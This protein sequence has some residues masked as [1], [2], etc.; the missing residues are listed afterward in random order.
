MHLCD[1]LPG[2][3][4]GPI[5]NMINYK[6]MGIHKGAEEKNNWNLGT[7]L[8]L[9]IKK[10][11]EGFCNKE[12]NKNS[13]K[14]I[15]LNNDINENNS[16]DKKEGNV[17]NNESNNEF[18]ILGNIKAQDNEFNEFSLFNE[19]VEEE[20][21]FSNNKK[22]KLSEIQKNNSLNNNINISHGNIL[23]DNFKN[24]VNNNNLNFQGILGNNN[25]GN[26]QN[27]NLQNNGLINNDIINIDP[28]LI[29]DN[30]INDEI[31]KDENIVDEIKIIYSK[32][33]ARSKNFLE[34]YIPIYT[35]II[36]IRNHFRK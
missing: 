3:S 7:L 12:D 34:E 25:I 15:N 9:P 27:Q 4:G 2:S 20:I 30:N 5:L 13:K 23:E 35:K 17:Q 1:T 26:N 10:F 22:G 28:N 6:V 19:D 18:S 24:Q 14:E 31:I 11:N 21:Y 8:Q 33:N 29:M 32:I 16:N 36:F